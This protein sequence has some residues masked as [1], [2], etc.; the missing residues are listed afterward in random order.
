MA[1]DIIVIPLLLIAILLGPMML[2][3]LALWFMTISILEFKDWLI[4][5][6]Q[7]KTT[8]CDRCIYYTGC[9]ELLCAVHPDKVLTK[10]AITCLDFIPAS[11][12]IPTNF[13]RSKPA[14]SPEILS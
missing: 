7:L 11:T 12:D 13:K 3:V 9:Q 8:P 4:R 6:Y 1:D 5:I 14:S 2:I 10:A